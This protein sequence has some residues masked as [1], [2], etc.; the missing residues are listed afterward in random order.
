MRLFLFLALAFAQTDLSQISSPPYTIL[1]P[2][3]M[4]DEASRVAALVPAAVERARD[5][6]QAPPLDSATLY[7]LPE[8]ADDP[9]G[10]PAVPMPEWAAGI[11]LPAAHIVIIRPQRVGR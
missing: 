9:P 7:L 2:P 1:S 8:G 6:L 3:S 4:A 10:A 11:A 5:G